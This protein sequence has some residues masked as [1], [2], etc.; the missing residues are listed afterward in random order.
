MQ[1]EVVQRFMPKAKKPEGYDKKLGRLVKVLVVDDE[2]IVRKL[3][4][5]VLKSAGYEIVSEAG[6]GRRAMD[7]YKMHR[8]DIVTL[9]VEMPVMDGYAALEQILK[10]NPKAVVVMLTNQ[11]EKYVVAKILNAG[12][13]DYILKPINRRV[14]LAKL[15]K[16][17][18][19]AD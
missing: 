14:I 19:V 4:S 3:L 6:D 10:I 12:A 13:K 17:R 5:Q 11:K 7:L 15:R 1:V 9:D 8:P 16:I 2:V 18:G